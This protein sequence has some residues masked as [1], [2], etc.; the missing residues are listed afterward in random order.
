MTTALRTAAW[1]RDRSG[2]AALPYRR[3][4]RY[5]ASTCRAKAVRNLLANIL[6]GISLAPYFL[7]PW[8]AIDLVDWRAFPSWDPVTMAL[9]CA[10]IS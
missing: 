8:L 5:M 3:G 4:F 7:I 9:T 10:D 1:P 2:A 6:N